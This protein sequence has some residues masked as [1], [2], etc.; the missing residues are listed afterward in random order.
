[1]HAATRLNQAARKHR[2][3]YSMRPGAVLL[4]AKLSQ[5]TEPVF[6]V[7]GFR[8][9]S[10]FDGLDIDGHDPETLAV[11][12]YTKELAGR[13]ADDFTTHDNAVASEQDSLMSNFKSEMELAFGLSAIIFWSSAL[14]SAANALRS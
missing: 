13:R 14:A 3:G 10:V 12:G 4:C 6:H 5:G 9:L 2:V 1:V 8:N 11:M 7:V